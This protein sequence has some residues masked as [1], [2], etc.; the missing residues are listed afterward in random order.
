MGATAIAAKGAATNENPTINQYLQVAGL[1]PEPMPKH[2][3]VTLDGGCVR[4][5]TTDG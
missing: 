1:R 5:T 2:V 4:N 3:A